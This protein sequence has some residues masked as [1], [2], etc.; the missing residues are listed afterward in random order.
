MEANSVPVNLD[1]DGQVE[2]TA[3]ELA[4]QMA[5]TNL[6]REISPEVL[7]EA[8]R[9]GVIPTNFEL[10][11]GAVVGEAPLP[12]L[13]RLAV[14]MSADAALLADEVWSN[15]QKLATQLQIAREISV[16]AMLKEQQA[17]DSADVA[18]GRRSARSLW[19][20]QPGH[21]DGYTFTPSQTSEFDKP[22]E[23]W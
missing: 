2:R 10:H 16:P 20:V 19:A 6:N 5:S 14:Q 7:G 3:L 18:A 4:A 11:I 21:L 9:S 23:G 8:L 15:M 13:C 22:G 1:A 17:K 12:L